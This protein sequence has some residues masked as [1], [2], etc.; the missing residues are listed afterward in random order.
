[1][2]VKNIPDSIYADELSWTMFSTF[3]STRIPEGTV[4][5]KSTILPAKLNNPINVYLEEFGKVNTYTPGIK[6]SYELDGKRYF[7]TYILSH[8]YDILKNGRIQN[9]VLTGSFVF[10]KISGYTRLSLIEV[11]SPLYNELALRDKCN[12]LKVLSQKELKPGKVYINNR[13]QKMAYFGFYSY[14]VE[15]YINSSMTSVMTDQNGNY[16]MDLSEYEKQIKT[17]SIPYPYAIKIQKTTNFVEET[18]ET[19]DYEILRNLFKISGNYSGKYYAK[20]TSCT[21]IN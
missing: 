2:N 12:I 15:K 20:Y 19:C 17:G 8:F 14:Q 9:G 21:K 13:G 3:D 7:G 18:N 16:F 11:G 6:L 4:Y 5:N 1:M 10:G